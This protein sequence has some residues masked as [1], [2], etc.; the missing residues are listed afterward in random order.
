MLFNRISNA[1]EI[2][3]LKIGFVPFKS[4]ASCQ[5]KKIAKYINVEKQAKES[6]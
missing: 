3:I 2:R 6:E 1:S 5:E 4:S